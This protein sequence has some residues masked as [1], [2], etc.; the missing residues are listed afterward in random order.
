MYKSS[1]YFLVFQIVLV[2]IDCLIA[3]VMDVC[4]LECLLFIVCGWDVCGL[5]FMVWNICCLLFMVWMFTRS[6]AGVPKGAGV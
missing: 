4:C 6:G 5:M 3:K 2:H 1:G